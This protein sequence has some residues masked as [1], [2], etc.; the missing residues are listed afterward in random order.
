MTLKI[1]QGLLKL[2]AFFFQK[3]RGRAHARQ[4]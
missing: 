1:K 3:T 4:A 2:V